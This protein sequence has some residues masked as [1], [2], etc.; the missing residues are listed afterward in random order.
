MASNF[1]FN[2]PIPRQ[3]QIEA[4]LALPPHRTHPLSHV[5]WTHNR[6][7][8]RAGNPSISVSPCP[9]AAWRLGL[10][11]NH[12]T[13][14]RP[15]GD[16]E[17]PLFCSFLKTL[18]GI[19][20]YNKKEKQDY[21]HTTV[22]LHAQTGQIESCHPYNRGLIEPATQSRTIYEPGNRDTRRL[23]ASIGRTIIAIGTLLSRFIVTAS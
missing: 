14:S 4:R 2:I 17:L 10:Y 20:H 23:L 8:R 16:E 9:R 1:F 19:E 22:S 18:K 12:G 3:I 5:S 13:A 7:D 6:G 21:T 11:V 15:H